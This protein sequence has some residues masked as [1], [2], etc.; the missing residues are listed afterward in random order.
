M[1]LV[2]HAGVGRRFRIKMINPNYENRK[3]VKAENLEVTQ[4]SLHNC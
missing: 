4:R 3:D 2:W 1:E